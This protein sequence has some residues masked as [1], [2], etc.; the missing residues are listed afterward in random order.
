M[1]TLEG[2]DGGPIMIHLLDIAVASLRCLTPILGCSGEPE[3]L[4]N[5]DTRRLRYVLLNASE[6]VGR[7]SVDGGVDGLTRLD[8][9]EHLGR[10]AASP[11]LDKATLERKRLASGRYQEVLGSVAE[12][13]GVALEDSDRL[14]GRVGDGN[15]S[16]MASGA[17]DL[18]G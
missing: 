17:G 3:T 6:L 15:L 16:N 7:G 8:G 12:K 18:Y 4:Q 11:V 2:R 13:D 5:G 14:A 10:D 9:L 1:E